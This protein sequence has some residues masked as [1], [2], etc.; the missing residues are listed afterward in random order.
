MTDSLV[1]NPIHDQDFTKLRLAL[2]QQINL[3]QSVPSFYQEQLETIKWKIARSCNSSSSKRNDSFILQV[4]NPND[5]SIVKNCIDEAL[6]NDIKNNNVIINL[7]GIID[8]GIGSL[9]SQFENQVYK[10]IEKRQSLDDHDEGNDEYFVNFDKKFKDKMERYMSIKGFNDGFEE[11]DN[12]VNF[13]TGFLTSENLSRSFDIF[14][15]F[16][17]NN[18]QLSTDD[19]NTMSISRNDLPT[20][21]FIVDN[22]ELFSENLERQTLLY[23]L[24]DFMDSNNGSNAFST[25]F[26]GVTNVPVIEQMLE[27]RVHSRFANTFITFRGILEFESF[28]ES[29]YNMI[30]L[31]ENNLQ[32]EPGLLE[33][34]NEWNNKVYQWKNDTPFGSTYKNMNLN[35]FLELVFNTNKNFQFVQHSFLNA[36]NP[37]IFNSDNWCNFDALLVKSMYGYYANT[38]KNSHNDLVQSLTNLEIL[39][40]IIFTKL[41]HNGKYTVSTDKKNQLKLTPNTSTLDITSKRYYSMYDNALSKPPLKKFGESDIKATWERLNILGLIMPRN[42][43]KSQVDLHKSFKNSNYM[44]YKIQTASTMTPSVALLNLDELRKAIGHKHSLY[45]YTSY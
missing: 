33:L 15:T 43:L 39:I 29:F 22:L 3:T 40:L 37:Y 35:K 44:R 13:T 25:C 19:D 41:I 2:L 16:L 4:F 12:K 28:E 32:E 42:K 26:I 27:K 1:K 38:L 10:N 17:S 11:H 14:L 9:L 6:T 34:K 8:T 36:L 31:S 21:I 18:G 23:N 20:I 30:L 7:S 5:N 24:F 45:K